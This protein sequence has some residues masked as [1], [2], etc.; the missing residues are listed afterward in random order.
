MGIAGSTPALSDVKFKDYAN[1][2]YVAAGSY[3]VTITVAGQ[4]LVVAIDDSMGT[5]FNL[6]VSDTTD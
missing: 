2:I 6:I 1:G 4:P 3:F 5:G